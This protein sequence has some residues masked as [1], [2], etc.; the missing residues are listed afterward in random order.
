MK[1][2]QI[3]GNQKRNKIIILVF[4]PINYD[5]SETYRSVE[6][7]LFTYLYMK[8]VE[9]IHTKSMLP[10]EIT[11]LSKDLQRILTTIRWRNNGELN[12]ATAP[13]YHT[14]ELQGKKCNFE[15]KKHG[16]H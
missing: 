6:Y 8:I 3:T 1:S 15:M 10:T 11:D 4:F 12:I 14:T 9:M 5:F 13:K 7:S 16:C 2:Y